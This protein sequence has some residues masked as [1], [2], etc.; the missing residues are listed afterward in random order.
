MD[1]A[2]SSKASADGT[3]KNLP[4]LRAVKEG[5]T[6]TITALLDAG[7]DGVDVNFQNHCAC[8]APAPKPQRTQ[9]MTLCARGLLFRAWQMATRH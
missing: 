3:K 9:N 1:G 7:E 8:H 6:S 4:L 2:G 5:K